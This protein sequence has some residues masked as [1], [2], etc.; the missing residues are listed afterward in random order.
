[1]RQFL[2]LCDQCCDAKYEVELFNI[3]SFLTNVVLGRLPT[4]TPKKRR[5]II[6]HYNIGGR[7]D[8]RSKQ[9]IF[10]TCRAESV[11]EHTMRL[12]APVVGEIGE[13]ITVQFDQF[14]ELKGAID[15]VLDGGFHFKINANDEERAALAAKIEWFEKSVH[16]QVKDLRDNG[17][18]VPREPLST[19]VFADGGIVRCLVI[20]MSRTGAAVSAGIIPEVGTP[21]AVGKLVGRV[22]RHLRGGFAVEFVEQQHLDRVERLAIK[23][24][25]KPLVKPQP[26]RKR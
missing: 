14:G 4:A 1:M 10:I 25:I 13:S 20:D 21:L 26:V 16:N 23:P 11:N 24:L 9:R 2:L 15:K 18:V 7:R 12:V 22:V 17:R 6:G 3:R 5:I 8:P 19:L